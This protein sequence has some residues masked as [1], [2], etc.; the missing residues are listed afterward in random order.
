MFTQIENPFGAIVP[1][2]Y[3][4][5][6]KEYSSSNSLSNIWRWILAFIALLGGL[7]IY[8]VWS[9]RNK[10][11]QSELQDKNKPLDTPNLDEII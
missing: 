1:V 6:N 4:A 3:S 9:E 2:S 10:E 5:I 8:L 11:N 7:I